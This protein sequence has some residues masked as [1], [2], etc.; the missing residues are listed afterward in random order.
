MTYP[1]KVFTI[2][3]ACIKERHLYL[4]EG[5]NLTRGI[6]GANHCDCCGKHK[7]RSL[8][9]INLTVEFNANVGSNDFWILRADYIP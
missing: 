7:P 2:C 1:S 3:N 8:N 5:D 9:Y 4:T 6:S